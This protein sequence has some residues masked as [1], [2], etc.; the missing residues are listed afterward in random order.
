M[1]RWT[2]SWLEYCSASSLS[3]S[4][5]NKHASAENAENTFLILSTPYRQ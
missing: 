2:G 1:F 3:G 4:N 5:K